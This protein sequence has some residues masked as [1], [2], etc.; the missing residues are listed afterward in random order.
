MDRGLLGEREGSSIWVQD[1]QKYCIAV[2]FT[3]CLQNFLLLLTLQLQNTCSSSVDVVVTLQLIMTAA[4]VITGY[5][6]L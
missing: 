3:A 6:M 2:G 4:N 5:I 1:C